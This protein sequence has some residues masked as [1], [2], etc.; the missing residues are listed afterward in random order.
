MAASR[1]SCSSG[2]CSSSSTATCQVMGVIDLLLWTAE[3]QKKGWQN[4]KWN[5]LP[6]HGNNWMFRENQAAG[7]VHYDLE[8]RPSIWL[9]YAVWHGYGLPSCCQ[10]SLKKAD[11]SCVPPT[12]ELVSTATLD[13]NVLLTQSCGTAFQLVLLTYLIGKSF[14]IQHTL[15]VTPSPT[16]TFC[17]F[18]S[19]CMTGCGSIECRYFIP[20]T[21]PWARN[22]FVGQSTWNEIQKLDPNCLRNEREHKTDSKIQVAVTMSRILTKLYLRHRYGTTLRFHSETDRTCQFSLVHKNWKFM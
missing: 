4:K 5:W 12:Q 3:Y 21:T 11:V 16:R 15:A 8:R 10:L 22:N 2:R 20:R 17:I 1:M 18:K 13:T 6:C 9:P 19:P 7:R 14:Y